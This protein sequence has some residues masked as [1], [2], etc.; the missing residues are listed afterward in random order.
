M[1][2]SICATLLICALIPTADAQQ[3]EAAVQVGVVHA[4]RAKP[5]AMP[6]ITSSHRTRAA[7]FR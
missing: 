3:K 7:E 2:R 1:R 6:A 5:S 4:E